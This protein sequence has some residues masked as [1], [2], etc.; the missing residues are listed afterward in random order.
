MEVSVPTRLAAQDSQSGASPKQGE[1]WLAH[2][3]CS[4][5]GDWIYLL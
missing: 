2:Q 4:V 5:C 3:R 1:R